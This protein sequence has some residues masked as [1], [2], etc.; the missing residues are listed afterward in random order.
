MDAYE[1]IVSA[2][3][4]WPRTCCN[5]R[6]CWRLKLNTHC[7]IARRF[8]PGGFFLNLQLACVSFLSS[9]HEIDLPFLHIGLLGLDFFP[10]LF[11]K[12]AFIECKIHQKDDY[13]CRKQNG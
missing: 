4:Y 11:P 3:P 8:T 6:R 5:F 9:R 7:I 2:R 10:S 12:P 13:H 1:Q